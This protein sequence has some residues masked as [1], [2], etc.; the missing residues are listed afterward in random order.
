MPFNSRLVVLIRTSSIMF[1][2]NGESRHSCLVPDLRGKALSLSPQSM[3]FAMGFH[4]WF[5]LCWNSFWLSLV[6][7]VYFFNHERM[8]KFVKQFSVSVEVIMG[9]F[10]PSF[11]YCGVL[12]WSSFVCWTILASQEQITL[13]S[14]AF[15]RIFASVFIMDVVFL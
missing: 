2:T 13:D 3:T 12:H 11:C 5:S 8:L 1:T 4:P 6:L 10:P 14:A 15:V 9:L 7:C